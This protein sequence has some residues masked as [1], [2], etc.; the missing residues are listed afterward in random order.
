MKVIIIG[1]GEQARVVLSILHYSRD[2][3][4][5]GLIDAYDNPSI[6]GME[7]KGLKVLGGIELLPE[8][9]KQ[10]ITGAIVALGDNKKRGELAM[11]A[12]GIGF[13]LINAIHPSAVIARE[14]SLGQGLVISPNITINTDAEIMDNAIINT[15]A[16]IE[17]DCQI[18]E[19]SHIAP[20]AHL[21][22]GV[23][24]GKNAFVGIG[25]TII[26]DRIIGE[27]SIIGAGA[28]VINDVPANVTVVGV[29][30]KI[31][32]EKGV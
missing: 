25:S 17:H 32:K 15:G 21:A 16:I 28:V 5:A 8:L 14:V 13:N 10:G 30:A 1:A 31:I 2:I 20:G 3:I 24:V 22:G 11:K 12:K 18:G 26:D 23:K 4:L 27:N 7:I 19:N 9:Y 29:P 6:W